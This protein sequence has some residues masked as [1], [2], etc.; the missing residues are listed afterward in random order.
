MDHCGLVESEEPSVE[1]T[2]EL[3]S[4]TGVPIGEL[5]GLFLRDNSV[6]GTGGFA[7]GDALRDGDIVRCH[8]DEIR[9]F[10]E[11]VVE[12]GVLFSSM[13]RRR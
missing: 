11:C 6:D 12:C 9:W 10:L 1:S 4:D 5:R 3:E 13:T 8:F 2:A 7:D